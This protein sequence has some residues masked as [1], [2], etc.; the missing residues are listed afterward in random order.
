MRRGLTL[1]LAAALTLPTTPV[2][3]DVLEAHSAPIAESRPGLADARMAITVKKVVRA[4]KPVRNYK[5]SSAFR[6]PHRRSHDGIDLS[7]RRGTPVYAVK[8]GRVVSA[9]WDGGYGRKVTVDHGGGLITVYA[10]L[11]SMSVKAGQRLRIGQRLGR[12]GTSGR[13][14]GAHLHFEVHKQ[15]QIIDPMKWLR[16][17]G[18]RI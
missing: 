6:G 4:V 8:P 18:V 12:V 15:G 2:A 9:D 11:D 16:T 13:T 7:A 14:T 10:H 5:F 17:M 3:A 1:A